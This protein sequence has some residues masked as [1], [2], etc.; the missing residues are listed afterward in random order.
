MNM[1]AIAVADYIGFV[2]LIAMLVSSHIR[3]SAKLD[4]YRLFTLIAFMSAVACVVDVLM[5]Y[6]DGKSGV[7]FRLINLVGNTYCFFTNPFFA[8]GWCMYTE[9]KLYKS[10]SRIRKRYRYIAAP[11]IVFMALTI[12]NIFVPIIFYLDEANVY[13]RLPL[14][15]AF[16]AMEFLYMAYSV[17]TVWAY[18]SKYG[19]V[20]FFPIWLMIGPIL[21]GCVLQLMF[22]GLS[23]IWVSLAIG[24][25]SIYMSM[26]NEFSYLDTLTGLYNRAYLDYLF[27]SYTKDHNSM[28]GGIMVD[29]D[30]FKSINDT[31]GHSVGDEALIDVARVLRF[32]KPDKALAIRFA[33]DEFIILMKGCTDESMQK[34]IQDIRKEVDLF[35]DTEGRQ[36]KLSLSLGYTIYDPEKDNMDSFFKHMDDNMYEEKIRKHSERD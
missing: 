15:Y 24:L 2:L 3:R 20:R 12:V 10:R 25:T 29:V 17:Y 8:I 19:K 28:L 6:C 36:Y 31:F 13:H 11:G 30:Y 33:G 1:L 14:S 34:I 16:F 35:N 7:V 23:L 27:D 26:Q 5:F 22:Y 9:L 32:S 18:E 4:E 21:V